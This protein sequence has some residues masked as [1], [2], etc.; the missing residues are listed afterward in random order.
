MEVKKQI[1]A[2]TRRAKLRPINLI[3]RITDTD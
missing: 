3:N 2:G 1:K